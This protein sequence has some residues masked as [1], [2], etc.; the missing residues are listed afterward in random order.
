MGGVEPCDFESDCG[1]NWVLAVLDEVCLPQPS[2]R[3]AAVGHQ[4]GTVAI[5]QTAGKQINPGCD[6]CR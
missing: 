2:F 1:L 6:D 4:E 3:G 5:L